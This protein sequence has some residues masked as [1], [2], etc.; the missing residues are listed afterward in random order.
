MIIPVEKP[1]SS[2][3]C[4]ELRE[5]QEV[6]VPSA[7]QL[8]ELSAETFPEAAFWVEKMAAVMVLEQVV[9]EGV[10]DEVVPLAELVADEG[11]PP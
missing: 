4:L 9:A 2:L 5:E 6:I 8:P 7:L 1:L 11:V 10:E 3:R